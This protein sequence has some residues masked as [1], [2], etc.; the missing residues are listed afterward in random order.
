MVFH[1]FDQNAD[2]SISRAELR[3]AIQKFSKPGE[4]INL[5]V[6]RVMAAVLQLSL[7]KMLCGPSNSRGYSAIR[8]GTG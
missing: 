2:N 1:A 5:F 8:T 6:D 4:A 3:D 7:V